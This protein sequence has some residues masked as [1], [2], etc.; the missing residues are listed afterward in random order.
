MKYKIKLEKPKI[1]SMASIL[2][3]CLLTCFLWLSLREYIFFSIYLILTVM[4]A[5][6]YFFTYYYIEENYLVIK[7]GF[8]IVK[9][10]YSK[11]LDI[12]KVNE[13]IKLKF[14]KFNISI[15]PS[16]KDDFYKKL[17]NKIGG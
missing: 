12:E 14:K 1:V 5:H 11:I 17:K 3:L 8:L 7:L 13:A 6:M 15:Y 4:L 2:F 16:N 10:K 9:F